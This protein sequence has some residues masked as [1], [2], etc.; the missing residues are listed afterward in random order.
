[1]TRK[2]GPTRIVVLDNEAARALLSTR[3]TDSERA[4]VI[5][6]IMAANGGAVVPLAVRIEAGWRRRDP[7][8]AEANRFAPVDATLERAAADRAVEFRRFHAGAS[9]VDVAVAVTAERRGAIQS[10]AVVEV[11]TSDVDDLAALAAHAE[12]RFHVARL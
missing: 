7:S 2:A 8:A 1:M 5:A 3:P 6:A 4:S 11:L 12:P 10:H 9:V